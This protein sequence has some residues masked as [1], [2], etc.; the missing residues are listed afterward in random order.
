MK[1]SF[2]KDLNIATIR[3]ESAWNKFKIHTLLQNGERKQSSINAYLGAMYSRTSDSI[4][5]IASEIVIHS[6]NLTEKLEKLLSE[7]RQK[8]VG[9]MANLF[10]CIEDIPILTAMKIFYS[11]SSLTGQ[12]R[13]PKYQRVD[14]FEFIKIPREVCDNTDVRKEFERIM[15]KQLVDYKEMLKPTREELAKHY[16]INLESSHE[17]ASLKSR[18]FDVAGYLLPVGLNTNVSYLMSARDWS[19]E[20]SYLL[21]SDSVV[22]N[23]LADLL[24]SLLGEG[25]LE[26]KGYIKEADGLI[27]DVDANCNRK[28]STEEVIN[29]LK[30]YISTEQAKDIPE[31][32]TESISV[33]Y[34]PDCT[35]TLISHYE[36]LINPLG[37]A[38]EL[39]FSDEDQEYIS[40]IL[41]ERHD[42]NNT[43]GNMGQSGAIKISGFASL[44]VLK[45]LNSFR[46][47]E[48][49]IP[50]LHDS[51]DMNQELDRRNDQC[52]YLC[53]YLNIPS[54]SKLKKEYQK[55]LEE[56]YE[57]IKAW[58]K[59]AMD[60]MSEDL[61]D[62]FTKYLLPHAHSTKYLMYGSFDD[63]QYL[64]NNGIRN[65]VHIDCRVLLYEWLR[66]LSLKDPI[67]R[68]LLKKVITPKVDDKFQFVDRS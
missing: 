16:S 38:H 68:S 57:R 46:S 43:I 62:E 58:R 13:S 60:F 34:S 25:R 66:L 33:T 9:D 41:F 35:E 45:Y 26:L 12:E 5:D 15:L 64:I 8:V 55:R 65:G 53:T 63:L 59:Y 42:H 3:S 44:R 19:S 18:V 51:V 21:A 61:V 49:F 22:D 20:I 23:E 39:E 67:W 1:I 50:L 54:M 24:I 52:F 36:S 2:R 40:D 48:R 47:L 32:E 14:K 37:S 27:G 7:Y 30:K 6:S 4:L 31:R 28:N 17:S 29:Y 10:V 56:T 11:N